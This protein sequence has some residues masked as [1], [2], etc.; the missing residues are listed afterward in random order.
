MGGVDVA[1]F[2]RDESPAARFSGG[3]LDMA[4]DAGRKAIRAAGL[5]SALNFLLPKR[6]ATR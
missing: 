6:G 1:V 2:E 5:V 4:A 3:S